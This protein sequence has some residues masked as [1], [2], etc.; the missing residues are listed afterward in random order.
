[1]EQK[2]IENQSFKSHCYN[3]DKETNQEILFK[4]NEIGPRE[5][6]FR[7]EQGDKTESAW[8][9]VAD[10]WTISK[11]R[12]CD[13]INFTHILRNSPHK[14]TDLVFQFPRKPLR[15]VPKWMIKLPMN[16]LEILQEV[17]DSINNGQLILSLTGIRTLLDTYI[18]SKVGDV[19][20][21]KQKIDRLVSDGIITS[22][23]ATV[24]GTAIEAGNA[25]A[26][27]GYK[28]E[29]ETLFQILDIVENLLQSEIVDRAADTIRG[30]TP[31][32]KS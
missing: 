10:I 2:G 6:V 28:P 9:V 32:K 3:C 16:Y 14:E 25:S 23:K 15:A 5:V 17:Y 31:P 20:T 13:R 21:F 7:N 26:H 12:G 22:S 30:K 19:G 4:E 11:C 1:M 18:V 24:L 8:E 27:R 29:R